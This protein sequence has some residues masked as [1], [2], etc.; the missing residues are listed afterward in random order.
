[1]SE[2]LL[3]LSEVASIVGFKRS[4][5]FARM[6]DGKFPTAV[7]VGGVNRWSSSAIAQYVKDALEGKY[8]AA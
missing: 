5:I 6:K 7:R 4:T 1:M 3:R 2:R 8:A